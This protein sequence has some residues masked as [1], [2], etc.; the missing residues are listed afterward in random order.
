[1]KSSRSKL[2]KECDKLMFEILKLERKG[3]CQICGRIQGVG[4]FHILSK[5]AYPRLRYI[6][7]NLL[8]VC[9]Y[10]CH[11]NWHHDFYKARIVEQ[12]IKS[13]IGENYEEEL[14]RIN[15]GLPK[16][17]VLQLS[18]IKF[19]LKQELKEYWNIII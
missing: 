19:A 15:I 17:D 18:K 13:L 5:G 12:K 1:M 3:I 16:L 2:I 6:K 11:K 7:S 14:Q 4:T 8:L 9:F 10:P